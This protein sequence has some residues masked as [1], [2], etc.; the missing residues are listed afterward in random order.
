MNAMQIIGPLRSLL[1]WLIAA[2]AFK[3]VS[4][5]QVGPLADNI[6]QVL[7]AVVTLVVMV[8]SFRD[9]STDRQIDRVANMPT[10]KAIEADYDHVTESKLLAQNPKVTPIKKM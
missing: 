5:E 4:P 10:V 2:V 3:W 1:V 6:I 7:T 8:W 9:H